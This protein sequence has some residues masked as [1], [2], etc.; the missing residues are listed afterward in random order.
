MKSSLRSRAGI[1]LHVGLLCLLIGSGARAVAGPKEEEQPRNVELTN[2]AWEAHERGD[3]EAAIAAAERCIRRFKAEAD[4]DE[5]ELEDKHAVLPPTGKVSP[6]QKKAIF[7][8]GVL[9]DVATCYWIE[10]HSAQQLHRNEQA[11][12]AYQA[13]AKYRYA[14]T[15]DKR[16]W[17]WSPAEDASDR[18]QDVK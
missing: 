2:K 12:G 14:R 5:K 11:R 7:E 4:K 17:F 13:A 18:L 9:N 1:C 16:G 6:Q 8:Q 10:G 3:Y 15:W